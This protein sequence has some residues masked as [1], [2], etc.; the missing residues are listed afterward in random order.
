MHTCVTFVTF[1]TCFT[2]VL[3]CSICVS[4]EVFF[5]LCPIRYFNMRY[6]LEDEKKNFALIYNSVN[7][8]IAFILRNNHNN[9]KEI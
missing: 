8:L 4:L 9:T 6:M 5:H 7:D 3:K 1:L 2:Y